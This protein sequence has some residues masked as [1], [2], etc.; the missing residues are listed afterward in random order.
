MDED[1]LFLLMLQL[2]G[3]SITRPCVW[4]GWRS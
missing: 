3:Q 4:C 1:L 2:S